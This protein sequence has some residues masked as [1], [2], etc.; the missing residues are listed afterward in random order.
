MLRSAATPNRTEVHHEPAMKHKTTRNATPSRRAA[1]CAA[2]QRSKFER[3]LD[4]G[5]RL[6]ED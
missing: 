5:I 6:F 3:K 2:L 1:D 4:W